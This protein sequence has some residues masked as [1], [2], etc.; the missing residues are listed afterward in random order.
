MQISYG[1]IDSSR[2]IIRNTV[3]EGRKSGTFR[4]LDIGGEAG[5]GWQADIV[6]LTVDIAAPTDEHNL[7][8]D[9]CREPEWQK[10][11]D[12]VERD[13]KF[14]YCICTNVLEDIYNPVTA[15]ELMPKVAKRGMITNP[16]LLTELSRHDS[17][18]WTGYPHHRWVFD[19]RDGQVF[20]APK[21]AFVENLVGTQ[22]AFNRAATEIRYEWSDTINYAMFL[23]N[24]LSPPWDNVVQEYVNFIN[25]GL[26]NINAD[27]AQG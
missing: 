17:P 18:T 2:E 14:D 25:E 23:N 10:L 19:Q 7:S 21:L 5:G 3:L 24:Y 1:T 20:L 12:I 8:M 27:V 4:V 11:L 26:N 22:L 15:L 9:I 16:S 13:G 6:T